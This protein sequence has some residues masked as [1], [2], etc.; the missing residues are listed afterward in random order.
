MRGISWLTENRIASKNDFAARS[1]QASRAKAPEFVGSAES[2]WLLLLLCFYRNS[3]QMWKERGGG[4]GKGK[5]HPRTD[6]EGPEGEYRHGSTLSLT[7]ALDGGGRLTS[8][9]GR[10]TPGKDPVH[11]V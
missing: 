7:S 5:V 8:R 10:L 1:E 9:P 6:H 3:K 4:K 2:L 11:I